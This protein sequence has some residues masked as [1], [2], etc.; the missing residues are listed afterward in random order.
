MSMREP[1]QEKWGVQ[2]WVIVLIA[3]VL[4]VLILVVV[5]QRPWAWHA[6]EPTPAPWTAQPGLYQIPTIGPTLPPTPTTPTP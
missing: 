3:A 5:I 1:G 2:A 4:A 6:P